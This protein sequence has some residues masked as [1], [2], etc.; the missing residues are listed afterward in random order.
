MCF[1]SG[2]TF[3]VPR[4]A[5]IGVRENVPSLVCFR[6][7]RVSIPAPAAA[8]CGADLDPPAARGVSAVS[9]LATP[10]VLE[11]A[12]HHANTVAELFHHLHPFVLAFWLGSS[13][14]TA[15]S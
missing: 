2:L 8:V 12:A 1:E 7:H 5:A 14:A 13:P 3:G 9:K 4:I 6:A 10:F 15:F 11:Y